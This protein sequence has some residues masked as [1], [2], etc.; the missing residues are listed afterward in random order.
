MAT[1]ACLQTGGFDR[2]ASAAR[3][4]TQTAWH[5]SQKLASTNSSFF[6]SEGNVSCLCVGVIFA[7]LQTAGAGDWMTTC[8]ESAHQL[9]CNICCRRTRAVPLR[10]SNDGILSQHNGGKTECKA[11][12]GSNFNV[13]QQLEHYSAGFIGTERLFWDKMIYGT[14]LNRRGHPTC[15]KTCRVT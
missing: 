12:A 9:V 3:A 7:Q 15:F 13:L 11:R 4:C 5:H 2:E 8:A 14:R 1:F 6:S 10:S